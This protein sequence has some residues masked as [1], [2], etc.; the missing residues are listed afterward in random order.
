[1]TIGDL[2]YGAA[3]DFAPHTTHNAEALGARIFATWAAE[4]IGCSS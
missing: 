2:R 4:W 1:M 3:G